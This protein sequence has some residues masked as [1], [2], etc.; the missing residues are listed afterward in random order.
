MHKSL[1]KITTQVRFYI[2]IC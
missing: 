2:Y 1:Y